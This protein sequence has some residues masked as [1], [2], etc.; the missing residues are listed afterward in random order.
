MQQDRCHSSRIGQQPV[1]TSHS[2]VNIK[3]ANSNR[4]EGQWR[5]EEV[6]LDIYGLKGSYNFEEIA[7]FDCCTKCYFCKHVAHISVKR[8]HS[9]QF[10][11][12][13]VST[14]ELDTC[15]LQT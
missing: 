1:L 9:W 5:N 2:S 10:R 11:T 3:M 7:Q 15:H 13:A 8:T 6:L 12:S 4:D 14:L